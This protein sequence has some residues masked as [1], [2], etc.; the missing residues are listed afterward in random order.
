MLW[1][2]LHF[3]D[4]PIEV[5]SREQAPQQHAVAVAHK[6]HIRLCNSAATQYGIVAG[7]STATAQVLC[8]E[9]RIFQRDKDKEAN[10]LH[11]LAHWCYR[12]TPST[13]LCKTNALLLEISSSLK[14]FKGLPALLEKIHCGITRQGYNCQAGL[15]HTPGAA[16]LL[17][18]T[19]LYSVN[20]RPPW[21]NA[22]GETLDHNTLF[23][24]LQQIP[25]TFLD[26]DN[27]Q[28]QVLQ[29][30]GFSVLGDILQLPEAAL[31]K[32]LGRDFLHRLQRI[33]GQ[34]PDPQQAI[35]P[36]IHF[37]SE[38]HFLDGVNSKQMLLFP[39]KRLLQELGGF[40]SSRQLYCR[41]LDWQLGSAKER[42]TLTLKPSI[43]QHE[44]ASLLELSRLALEKADLPHPVESIHLRADQFAP[45]E[46]SS[47][48]L[49]ADSPQQQDNDSGAG[50]LLLDKLTVRL[51]RQ[52]VCKLISQDSHIPERGSR[53]V[54]CQQAI[55][56]HPTDR[57]TPVPGPRPTWLFK[58]PVRLQCREQQLYLHREKLK[59]LRGPE[60]IDCQWWDRPV[61]RDY[62]IARHDSGGLYWVFHE[63]AHGHWYAHGL[64]A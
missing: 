2:C 52:R 24:Q 62:F 46:F 63:H 48:S 3:P 34:R 17:A 6:K 12:F 57:D 27:K 22:A 13:S 36:P 5:F 45:L 15:A 30:M 47:Q 1:I 50:Q 56:P 39:A 33:T 55:P 53:L 32:R 26:C 8:P 16:S 9:L 14:L 60:R 42:L 25:L 49:L 40:L 20:T 61:R 59:L 54:A 18:R 38:L 37:Y 41:S 7:L 4:L 51:G 10:S 19:G 64:F 28:R 35:T 11:N 31:G 21:F 43:K 23:S 29:N 58:L 44:T